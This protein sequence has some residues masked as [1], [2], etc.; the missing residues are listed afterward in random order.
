MLSENR[1][2]IC[3]NHKQICPNGFIGGTNMKEFP[4]ISVPRDLPKNYSSA[5]QGG[6]RNILTKN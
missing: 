1:A 3:P 2:N 4:A 5:I 6:N